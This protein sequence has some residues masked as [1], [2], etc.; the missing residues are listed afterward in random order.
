MMSF[1]NCLVPV[2]VLLVGR[3]ICDDGVTLE[4]F[5][6]DKSDLAE[7][8][9]KEAALHVIGKARSGEFECECI[10]HTCGDG[11][12]IE[13]KCVDI[14]AS[15]EDHTCHTRNGCTPVKLHLEHSF[16]RSTPEQK[17]DFSTKDDTT[18]ALINEICLFKSLDQAHILRNASEYDTGGFTGWAYIGMPSGMMMTFPGRARNRFGSDTH[19]ASCEPYDATL[20]PWFAPA[21]STRKALVILVHSSAT[22]QAKAIVAKVL[23]TLT[24]SDYVSVL[25]S[26]SGTQEQS[27]VFC[28]DVDKPEHVGSATH[29]RVQRVCLERG[30][31]ENVKRMKKRLDEGSVASLVSA[32]DHAFDLLETV[33]KKDVDK[34]ILF[35][36]SDTFSPE[37]TEDVLRAVERRQDPN[38]AISVLGYSFDTQNS[39]DG[40]ARQLSC[41]NHGVSMTVDASADMTTYFSFISLAAEH[42]EEEPSYVHFTPSYV[43]AGHLGLV[44]TTSMA[45][46]E[47]FNCSGSSGQKRRFLGVTGIDKKVQDLEKY[48]LKDAY[49]DALDDITRLP[50]IWDV[51]GLDCQLQI[52]RKRTGSE[53]AQ[54]LD[55]ADKCFRVGDDHYYFIPTGEKATFEVARKKCADMGGSIVSPDSSQ[56]RALFASVVPR[57]GVWVQLQRDDAVVGVWGEVFW[58]NGGRRKGECAKI[59]PRG[60]T[61][62]IVLQDCDVTLPYM[63]EFSQEP[64]MCKG[65]VLDLVAA[66]GDL[67]VAEKCEEKNEC[68]P[69]PVPSIRAPEGGPLCNW[70]PFSSNS[71]STEEE[72]VCCSDA[73]YNR[74]CPPSQVT[75]HSNDNPNDRHLNI[76]LSGAAVL[77][78]LILLIVSLFA[79]RRWISRPP[80]PIPIASNILKM[81]ERLGGGFSGEVYRATWM[82]EQVAA[83]VFHFPERQDAKNE[84]VIFRTL[85][86]HPNIIRCIGIRDGNEEGTVT[87][88]LELMD[89]NLEDFMSGPAGRSGITYKELFQVLFDVASGLDHLHHH[90]FLHLDLKPRNVL[91][92]LDADNRPAVKLC[93]FG[94]SIECMT[95]SINLAET[96]GTPGYIARELQRVSLDSVVKAT[97][98]ADIYSLGMIMRACLIPEPDSSSELR[99]SSETLDGIMPLIESC[100]RWDPTDRPSAREVCSALKHLMKKD[101][102]NRGVFGGPSAVDSASGDVT[103]HSQVDVRTVF[104]HPPP[105]LWLENAPSSPA[106]SDEIA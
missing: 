75:N 89:M 61:N 50:S 59:D 66:A 48:G 58:G 84:L 63:C 10:H 18:Q 14:G 88:I 83:K 13:N 6:R 85:P 35:M 82:E 21:M 7:R 87:L 49:N 91:I 17:L 4:S 8:F 40:L 57:S 53:C 16:L 103:E 60:R 54:K 1:N 101:W 23:T 55:H 92:S 37:A 68:K 99:G 19:G 41:E 3:A 27:I 102:A 46:Y 76:L 56:K 70:P 95:N 43:D 80:Q 39:D 29:K 51:E 96:R 25:V 11:F 28:D 38:D 64:K 105:R 79:F 100:T 86:Q 65:S 45:M 69:P 73:D 15:A 22:Q 74:T 72:R 32:F 104:T 34:M 24:Y 94:M 20:R 77:L 44:I 36:A 52:L 98:K 12:D 26:D 42:A 67:D 93:D 47:E 78:L 71:I 81:G 90:N 106:G 9:A 30:T 62:N 33:S 2:F 5:K 31:R 97:R